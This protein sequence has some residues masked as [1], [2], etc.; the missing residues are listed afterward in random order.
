MRFKNP[1]MP[2]GSTW[3]PVVGY[4]GLYEVSNFGDVRRIAVAHGT[5]AGYIIKPQK[6]KNREYLQVRLCRSPGNHKSASLH[7]VVCE[8]F[9]G[10]RP[11]GMQ[12]NHKNGVKDDNR[13]DNL[14]WVTPSQNTRHRFD[15]LKRANKRGEEHP[16][17]Q[18]TE[19]DVLDIRA[20]RAAG[21]TC[22]QIAEALARNLS[23]VKA[24]ASRRLWR[25]V[26]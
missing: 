17:A 8:A 18:F 12:V 21:E 19:R 4:E 26:P 1:P 13:A 23:S 10:R 3:R 9:H 22:R 24:I 7:S 25:H 14:E 5:K 16:H 6:V 11:P 2:R 15:V 20:R